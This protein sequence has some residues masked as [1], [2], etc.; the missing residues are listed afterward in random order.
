[1]EPTQTQRWGNCR[2]QSRVGV[3]NESTVPP[4]HHWRERTIDDLAA[5]QRIAVPQPLDEMIGAA[6][7]LWDDEEDFDRFIR[8][9]HDRR[10]QRRDG[11]ESRG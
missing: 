9:I 4:G 1:M 2:R 11:G 3:T 10:T 7:E 8:G 6:A 5:Q